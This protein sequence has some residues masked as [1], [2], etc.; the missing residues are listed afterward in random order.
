MR[1]ATCNSRDSARLFSAGREFRYAN[2]F[3]LPFQF[4]LGLHVPQALA[5]LH[6]ALPI[7]RK[8]KLGHLSILWVVFCFG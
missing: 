3:S 6:L 2:Q 8:W 1:S 7:L 4:S 5:A